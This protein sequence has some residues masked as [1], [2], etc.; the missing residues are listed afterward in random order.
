MPQPGHIYTQRQGIYFIFFSFIIDLRVFT[1]YTYNMPQQNQP[2][3]VKGNN[4]S[5]RQILCIFNETK[6]LHYNLNIPKKKNN[7]KR[8]RVHYTFL[9]FLIILICNYFLYKF[10]YSILNS[11]YMCIN[12]KR[13]LIIS[14]Y[15]NTSHFLNR[16][17]VK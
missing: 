17:F 14:K 13:L 4:V 2:K 11:N 15:L 7:A 5:C 9:F 3:M 10:V 8:T 6:N 1:S 12:I 16:N